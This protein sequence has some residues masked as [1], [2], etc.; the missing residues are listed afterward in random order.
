MNPIVPH[1]KMKKIILVLITAVLLIYCKKEQKV[2]VE[3]V[4]NKF[5]EYAAKR[6]K[7][8]YN[9]QKIDS[10]ANSEKVSIKTGFAFI[11]K[12]SSD[13]TLGL[14][15]YSKTDDN[16]TAYVYDKG[17]R[18]LIS[19]SDKTYEAEERTADDAIVRPGGRLIVTQVFHLD[20]VYYKSVSLSRTDKNYVLKYKYRDQPTYNITNT[21]VT[22]ELTKDNFFPV[23]ITQTENMIG[24]RS[25]NQIILSN[26]KINE[27]TKNSIENYKSEFKDFKL[28]QPEKEVQQ[29]NPLLNNELPKIN[30]SD[31][32][33]PNE[34]ISLPFNSLTLIDFWEVW[35]GPCIASF[36]K[37]EN[38]K[39]KYAA[40][41][42][43]I[44]IVT[45]DIEKAKELVK[46]KKTT[47]QNLIG[48]EALKKTFSVNS[49]PRYLLVDSN[50]ILIK[51][52]FGF[53]EQIEKDIKELIKIL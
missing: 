14:S 42:K 8:A 11:D 7:V 23:K 9:I 41:L 53:S 24:N 31:L 29:S 48:N 45:E 21:E 47:Y 43:V 13:E 36:P 10:F 15:F 20:T 16:P 46:L 32:F 22:V 35:C 27:E 44:G 28:V 38:L 49:W 25:F 40:Q 1:F 6:E 33:N 26:I 17:T 51:E 52:Y 37:V 50:G 3:Y 39:N 19:K 34:T 18:Y 5:K 2:D 12:N 30:L 4:T